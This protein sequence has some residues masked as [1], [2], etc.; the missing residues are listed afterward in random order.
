MRDEGGVQMSNKLMIESLV[1]TEKVTDSRRIEV[2]L[3]D[4][5]GGRH[6]L[7]LS[8]STAAHLAAALRGYGSAGH[9]DADA[10]KLPRQF[11]VGRGRYE[12]LVLVRFEDDVPYGL[13]V[14]EAAELGHALI[15]ESEMVAAEPVMLMQ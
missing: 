6:T 1:R 15:E 10:T 13:D 12:R 3:S 9:R 11:A 14:R 7:S 2:V 5:D 4:I 8:A